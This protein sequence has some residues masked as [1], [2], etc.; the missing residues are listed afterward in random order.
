MV[1]SLQG[2]AYWAAMAYSHFGASST[3]TGNCKA[4]GGNPSS[5]GTTGNS[6]PGA[7]RAVD[8][9]TVGARRPARQPAARQPAHPTQPP[10]A[11]VAELQNTGYGGGYGGGYNILQQ[12]KKD[13][14]FAEATIIMGVI[15]SMAGQRKDK[16]EEGVFEYVP[17]FG[18]GAATGQPGAPA[19]V[20][21]GLDASVPWVR[22][23]T[24]KLTFYR[25]NAHSS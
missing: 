16:W 18:T 21:G 6:A 1:M 24:Y 2:T 12:V 25:G 3:L 5:Q 23:K 7:N 14:Y 17:M 10:T 8:N 20:T 9:G 13:V 15:T 22:D 11:E 19:L 4:V